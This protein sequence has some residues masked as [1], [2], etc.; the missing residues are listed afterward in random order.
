MI[1][2]FSIDTALLLIDVQVGVDDL[3]H[4][5]GVTGRRNNPD[6]ERN[7]LDLLSAWRSEG[8]PVAFTLHDSVEENSP[9]KLALPSGD[10][11]PGFS[12]GDD[13]IAE[14]RVVRAA[15]SDLYAA[16]GVLQ[17]LVVLEAAILDSYAYEQSTVSVPRDGVPPDQAVVRVAAGM[18]A[19]PRIILDR[20]I[21]DGD[22]LGVPLK[23]DPVTVIIPHGATAHQHV[24]A[25]VEVDATTAA[26]ADVFRVTLLPVSFHDQ[27]F[28]CDVVNFPA[29]DYRES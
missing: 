20:A 1:N 25:F 10:L 14:K 16:A 26:T 19:H 3:L 23:A 27:V 24:A 2:R 22:V 29:G 8:L 12:V 4:W 15:A 5:G 18:N 13:E 6:A 9:L 21:F 28:P 17:P 11:K 7:M